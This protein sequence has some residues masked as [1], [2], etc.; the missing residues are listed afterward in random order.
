M[1]GSVAVTSLFVSKITILAH[2]I[3]MFA[4]GVMVIAFMAPG[5]SRCR[6]NADQTDYGQ[7]HFHRVHKLNLS[8]TL[9]Y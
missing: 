3:G 7:N 1:C 9:N 8:R 4:T 6:Q 5:Q 2:K